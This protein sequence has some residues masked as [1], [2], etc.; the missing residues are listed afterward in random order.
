LYRQ[1]GS[2]RGRDAGVL[3]LEIRSDHFSINHASSIARHHLKSNGQSV[4]P[5]SMRTM[6]IAPR[7]TARIRRP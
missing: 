4:L 1:Q 2:D 7:S 6:P 3:P 5:E